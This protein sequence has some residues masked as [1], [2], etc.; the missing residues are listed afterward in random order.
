MCGERYPMPMSDIEIE[1]KIKSYRSKLKELELE[2]VKQ[3]ERMK[4]KQEEKERLLVKIKD[5]YPEFIEENLENDIEKLQ[6]QLEVDMSMF[7]AE[8]QDAY[9]KTKEIQ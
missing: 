7:E 6:N 9:R 8:L 4:S 2:V 5:I 1:K 3:E